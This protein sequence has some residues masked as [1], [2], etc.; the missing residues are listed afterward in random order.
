MSTA[1]ISRP[2]PG[3]ETVD[4]AMAGLIAVHNCSR[5]GLRANPPRRG[6]LELLLPS[7]RR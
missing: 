2:T 1:A 6:L 7:R 4:D 5:L 3:N